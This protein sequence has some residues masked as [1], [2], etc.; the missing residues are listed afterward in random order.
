MNLARAFLPLVAA[1]ATA[2]MLGA[3]PARAADPNEFSAAERLVFVDAHLANVKAPTALRYSF[4]RSGPLE[5]GFD[6]KVRIDVKRG[7]TGRCCSVHGAFLGGERQVKL[8]DVDGAEANPVILFFLEYDIREMARLTARKNGN[9]FRNRIRRSLVDEAQVRDVTLSYAG[10]EVAG[11]EV[12]LSPYASDPA[13]S[14]YERYAQKRYTFVLSKAVPG[15]VYQ[16]RSLLP[17][18]LPSD[19]PAQ[20]EVMTFVGSDAAT[21]K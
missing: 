5:P 6:D 19:P 3:A 9:Y 20:E 13:R 12:T 18:A 15:G 17:G 2:A 16:V 14:R 4:T 1:G 21:R 11:R 10:R 8:P 7:G